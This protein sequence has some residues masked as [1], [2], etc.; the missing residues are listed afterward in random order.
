[1]RFAA[2]FVARG[3]KVNF[4][5][6]RGPQPE[7]YSMERMNNNRQK[8]HGHDQKKRKLTKQMNMGKTKM[9]KNKYVITKIG[10]CKCVI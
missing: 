2:A 5:K 1:L 4:G 8:E 3:E 9:K 6:M 10:T 7:Q